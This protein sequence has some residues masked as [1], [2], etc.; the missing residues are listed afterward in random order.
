MCV[1]VCV[2]F[3]K[4]IYVIVLTN[5]WRIFPLNV[6]LAKRKFNVSHMLPH[7]QLLRYCFK[8]P[9]LFIISYKPWYILSLDNFFFLAVVLKKKKLNIFL[10]CEEPKSECLLLRKY[11]ATE[12]SNLKKWEAE[13]NLFPGNFILVQAYSVTADPNYH[14][15]IYVHDIKLK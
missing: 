6:S 2:C 13:V 4:L 15:F 3:G 5:V 14:N 7:F 9:N 11:S 8:I 10:S 1:G 12:K